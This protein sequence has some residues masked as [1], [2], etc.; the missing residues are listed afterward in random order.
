MEYINMALNVQDYKE[1]LNYILRRLDEETE[2]TNG[3]RY[4]LNQ[5]MEE[6][7]NSEMVTVLAAQEALKSHNDTF[8]LLDAISQTQNNLMQLVIDIKRKGG[9]GGGS[10]GSG[11]SSIANS[12]ATS[13]GLTQILLAG[14]KYAGDPRFA[15]AA[16]IVGGAMEGNNFL[17]SNMQIKAEEQK[18]APFFNQALKSSF[19]AAE[20]SRKMSEE[21]NQLHDS[22][23]ESENPVYGPQWS[24]SPFD[25]DP[26]KQII[27]L[28]PQSVEHN[29]SYQRSENTVNLYMTND[30]SSPLNSPV[31]TSRDERSMT[32]W[33][34]TMSIHLVK[35][36]YDKLNS[37][38]MLY[39]NNW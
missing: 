11:L 7:K 4:S 22:N 18:Y 14:S 1:Y 26:S 15:V 3:A 35:K 33:A 20:L 13:G 32:A 19:Y 17:L 39:S 16:A 29:T 2:E 9:I 30:F 12:A 31:G 37:G 36:I 23:A 21:R 27:T 6:V 28:Q 34:D 10:K 25:L 24:E 8:M 5:V 38:A